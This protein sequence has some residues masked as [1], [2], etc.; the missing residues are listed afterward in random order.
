MPKWS[1]MS[2]RR[3]CM[4]LV[5]CFGA[6]ALSYL[7]EFGPEFMVYAVKVCGVLKP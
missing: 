4:N 6:A 5:V 2:R 1:D 3:K 7:V